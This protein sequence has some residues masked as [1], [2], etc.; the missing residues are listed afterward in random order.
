ML[1][2][3]VIIDFNFLRL[4]EIIL[5]IP[6]DN[7]HIRFITHSHDNRNLRRRL[8]VKDILFI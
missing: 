5:I 1:C 4:Y 8:T 2:Q 3:N 6:F 7:F